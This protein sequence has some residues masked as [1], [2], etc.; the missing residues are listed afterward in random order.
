MCGSL[1]PG[2]VLQRSAF[3]PTSPV[4]RLRRHQELCSECNENP[5]GFCAVGFRLLGE[6]SAMRNEDQLEFAGVVREFSDRP[7]VRMYVG[8]RA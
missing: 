7:F 1:K 8:G 3:C 6:A 5:F 2:A 4:D